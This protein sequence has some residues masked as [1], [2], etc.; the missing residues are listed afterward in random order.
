[1]I[2]R[3]VLISA[4]SRTRM[5][6]KKR[7]GLLILVA[8]AVL[9]L[10]SCAANRYEGVV[11]KEGNIEPG[12]K[13]AHHAQDADE[14]VGDA[15]I[16]SAIRAKFSKDKT[17]SKSDINVDTTAGH[18]TLSGVVAGRAQADQAMRLGRSVEGVKT[19]RSNLV[20]RSESK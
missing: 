2:E 17:V 9:L 6:K 20:V 14:I 16:S 1:M 19:V 11:T 7:V 5:M 15:T 18:V 10:I 4:G 13:V 12:R 8:A 3:Q